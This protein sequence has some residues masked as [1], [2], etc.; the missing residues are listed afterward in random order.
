MLD[1]IIEGIMMALTW[2]AILFVAIGVFVAW[3][4][5]QSLTDNHELSFLS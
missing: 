4:A 5:H 2:K 3:Y 1:Q